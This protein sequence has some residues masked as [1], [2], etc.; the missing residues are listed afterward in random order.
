MAEFISNQVDGEILSDLRKLN[1][2]PDSTQ[3]D[4]FW[5]EVHALFEEYQAAV[6]ERRH[7][8]VLYLPFA[9]SIRELIDRVRKRKPDIA[10]PSDEWVRLQ[11]S[12]KNPYSKNA[13]KHTGR[14]P[15][16]FMVQRRQMRSEHADSKY[17]YIQYQYGKEFAV[18]FKFKD[19]C[20]MVCADDK[21]IILVGEP[22]H[23]VS[24]GVRAHNQ[25][26]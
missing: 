1:G 21:A 11:F 26:F 18:K 14:F 9:I 8:S 22:A 23:A 6:Q 5:N 10:I 25:S 16:K 19:E 24:S 4:E 13:M 3:F 15:I 7:D 20:L 2:K 12:P 17:A